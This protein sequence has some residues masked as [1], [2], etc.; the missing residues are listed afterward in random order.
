ML[1]KEELGRMDKGGVPFIR[2]SIN[3][4]GPFSWDKDGNCYLLV[5]LDPCS[6]WVESHT[7]LLL[8]S[9]RVTKF[10]YND[11][12]YKGLGI[13]HQYITIGNSKANG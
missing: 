11:L 10:L 4:A 12:V 5:A 6:K 8:H 7:I 13:V 3:A 2:W 9:W 1:S